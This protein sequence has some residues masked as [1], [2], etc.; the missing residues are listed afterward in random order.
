MEVAVNNQ[1]LINTVLRNLSSK[2]LAELAERKKTLEA[3]RPKELPSS[4]VD[5]TNLRTILSRYIDDAATGDCD[6][7]D[8]HYIFE[9]A[10]ETFYSKDVWNWINE[11]NG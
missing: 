10:L 7:D 5:L 3:D 6:E 1:H 4:E 2:E 8:V 11:R 9:T